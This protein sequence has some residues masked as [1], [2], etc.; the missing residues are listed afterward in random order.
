MRRKTCYR[1]SQ[2]PPSSAPHRKGA[3][4]V[5]GELSHSDHFGTR[6]H[7]LDSADQEILK[8]YSSVR[9]SVPKILSA[10]RIM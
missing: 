8:L 5:T 4:A 9:D 10:L 2:S 7:L 1:S 6:Y 3:L